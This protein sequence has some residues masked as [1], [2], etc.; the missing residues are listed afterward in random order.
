MPIFNEPGQFA[1][2]TFT[3]VEGHSTIDTEIAIISEEPFACVWFQKEDRT[4]RVVLEANP[5]YWNT[6]RGA[7]LEKVVFLN[8]VSQKEAIEKVCYREGEVDI[9]TNI[10]PTD[11]GRIESSPHAQLVSGN[12]MR[13]VAGIFNR[14]NDLLND[15][16]IRQALNHAIDRVRLVENG[17]NGYGEPSGG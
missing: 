9:V 15:G 11:A 17:L 6:A 12:A 1:T 4:P 8:D 13:V 10:S 2:E 5:H 14:A 16:R 3:L 7:R